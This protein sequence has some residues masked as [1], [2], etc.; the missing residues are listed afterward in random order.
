LKL[1]E[2]TWPEVQALDKNTV[3]P[4]YPIASFE[5]HAPHLPFLTDTMETDEIV[6]R[7][8]TRIPDEV[9]CL[10]TQWLGYSYPPY[11]LRWQHHSDL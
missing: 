3:V 7:L 2:M 11:A 9:I 8:N 4:V 6:N 10:P 5:Q 1:S